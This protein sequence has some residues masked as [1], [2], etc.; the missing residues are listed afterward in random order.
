MKQYPNA[1]FQKCV[2][3]KMRSVLNSIRPKEKEEVVSSTQ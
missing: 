2:V 1:K 3:H